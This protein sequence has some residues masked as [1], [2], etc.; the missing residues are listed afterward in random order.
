MRRKKRKAIMTLLALGT[1]LGY[2]GGAASIACRARMHHRKHF[3]EMVADTCVTAA[4]RVY[5]R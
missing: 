4:E 3:K 1:V 2:L 5:R